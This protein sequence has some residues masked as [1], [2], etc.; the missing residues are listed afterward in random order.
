M[1][2]EVLF[3]RAGQ[4]AAFLRMCVCG[5]LLGA[6]LQLSGWLHRRRPWLGNVWDAVWS[7]LLTLAVMAVML[8]S[9]GGVRLYGLL[10]LIL[11]AAVYGA[12]FRRLFS[13]LGSA[14]G[15]IYGKRRARRQETAN[16][17]RNTN[18]TEIQGA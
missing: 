17:E 3:A 14:W 18:D 8:L 10:G 15:K 16:Q 4:S 13:A 11:G 2:L 6:A 9:G 5:L 7:A 12:G 1:T